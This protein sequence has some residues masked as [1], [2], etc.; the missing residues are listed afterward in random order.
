M[1]TYQIFQDGHQLIQVFSYQESLQMAISSWLESV[2]HFLILSAVFAILSQPACN[3]VSILFN[4]PLRV[5]IKPQK[6]PYQVKITWI[7]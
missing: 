3:S 7:P 5:P 2:F 4:P 1:C 6:D